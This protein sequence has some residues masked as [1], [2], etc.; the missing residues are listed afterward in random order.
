VKAGGYAVFAFALVGMHLYFGALSAATGGQ[1]LPLGR[2][3]L[4]G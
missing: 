4:H 2:P 1:P 3:V